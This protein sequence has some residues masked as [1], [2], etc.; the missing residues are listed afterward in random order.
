MTGV[1]SQ[2]SGEERSEPP[3]NRKWTIAIAAVVVL[4]SAGI[5]ALAILTEPSAT[6]GGATKETAMLVEVS[7]FERGTFQPHISAT[8]TVEAERDII[9]RPQ[10]SGHVIYRNP[11]F[12]PGGFVDRGQVLLRI[13]PADYRNILEQRKSEL[14]QAMSDLRL[15]MGRQDVAQDDYALLDLEIPEQKRDLVLREPQLQAARVRVDAAQ[16]AVDQAQTDLGRT[17]IEAPFD[18]HVVRQ[19]ADVGSQVGPDDDL[20]RLVGQDRYRV[21]AAVPQSKLRW[22][23]IP[24]LDDDV[25]SEV[26]IRNRASWPEGVYRRGTVSRV[27]GALDEQTRMVRVLIIVPDPLARRAETGTDKPALMIGAFVDVEITGLPIEDV[28]RLPRDYLREDDTV[29]VMQA[30]ELDIRNVE[31]VTKDAK[32]A[33]IR[34]GLTDQDKVIT[35]NLATVVEGAGLRLGDDSD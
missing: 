2:N 27:I 30:D 16:A 9:F 3:V 8:G 34:R 20:G 7:Q 19:E 5:A 11:A 17:T 18:A 24:E 35:S 1:D 32:Y 14:G 13:D 26:T 23:A 33:Y 6:R 22:L 12:T 25:G 10:I 15:E 29:W 28:I 31:V 21:I 4:V